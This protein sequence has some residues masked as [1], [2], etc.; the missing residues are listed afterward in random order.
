MTGAAG[1]A[2]ASPLP[3]P[4]PVR[5]ADRRP[6]RGPSRLFLPRESARLR[7]ARLVPLPL[8]V[9]LPRQILPGST[10][11]LT[12]RCS[13]R[14]NLLC[15]SAVTNA[16]MGFLLAYAASHWGIEVHAVCVMSNHLHLVITDPDGNVPRFAQ[17]L[18]SLAGRALNL[19]HG[20][21]ES[22]WRARPYSLVRLEGPEDIVREMAYTFANPASAGL[23]DRGCEWPGL[24]LG[25][26]T[27]GSQLTFARPE[28][29]FG[30]R[31]RVP[32]S[33]TLTLVPPKGFESLDELKRRV[34]ERVELLEAEA[35]EEREREGRTILG[36]EAA[37]QVD[38]LS[39]PAKAEP[40]QRL[41]PR[42][43]AFDP[44]LL[45]R[46]RAR[47]RAFKRLYRDA[48]AKLREQVGPRDLRHVAFP[49]GTYLW[50]IRLGVN[51]L[52]EA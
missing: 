41:S 28:V 6:R 35:R 18:L 48:L 14:R 4:K 39:R 17:H 50:R 11:L 30:P 3:N 15:P 32:A 29:L 9:S 19:V 46:A 36:R 12:Q 22:F 25:P 27:F 21:T 43:A 52:A 47:W 24:W 16:I 2:R 49:A 13:E 37:L 44:E 8:T 42:F 51:C 31:T 40:R 34:V 10:Y 1:G 45:R 7:A 5:R 33:A 38:P 26:E 20:R 23:V